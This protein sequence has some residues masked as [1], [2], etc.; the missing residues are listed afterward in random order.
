MSKSRKE[1]E[2][3]Q[4]RKYILECA[5]RLFAEKGFDGI[6]VADIAK[7][8]EFSVGSLYLFFESKEALIRELLLERMKQMLEISST[9]LERD[10]PA[11]EK[12]ERTVDGLVEMFIEH[13]EF[14]KLYSMEVRGADSLHP[15]EEFGEEIQRIVKGNF[16]SIALIFRQG[17]DEGTFKD[18]IDPLYMALF[19]EACMH[20]LIGYT[21]IVGDEL[22]I[23]KVREGMQTMFYHGVLK[24][25]EGGGSE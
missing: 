19:L 4:R 22:P 2:H 25:E 6:T 13:M 18:N 12:L 24:R 3:G 7:A 14:F 5:E 1:L 21:F 17:I 11:K 20:S 10:V 23:E 15:L 9:Q 8:S 16:N